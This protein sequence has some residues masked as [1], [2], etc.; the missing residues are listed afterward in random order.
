MVKKLQL[1]PSWCQS[2]DLH[3]PDEI[4]LLEDQVVGWADDLLQG[5]EISKAN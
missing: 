3:H 1:P 5:K 2:R 4:H